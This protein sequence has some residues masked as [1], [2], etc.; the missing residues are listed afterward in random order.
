IG[1]PPGPDVGAITDGT[2]P[3]PT[4]PIPY[5]RYVPA[6]SGPHPIV[7]YFHGGGWVIGDLDSDDPFC[8]ELCEQSD[9]IVMSIDYR[10]APEARFPAA[11]DDAFAAVQWIAANAV[12]HGG[13]P[14]RLAVCGW[15]AGG[16]LAAVVC[17]LARD[18][19]GPAI[20]G[21]VLITPATDSDFTR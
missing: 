13:I 5:R 2:L 21:Q 1:R 18:A 15:S 3:G 11:V 17:Q 14:G 16:N 6:S 9:A 20:A 7:V 10:L 8:R 4:G 12:A 19:G